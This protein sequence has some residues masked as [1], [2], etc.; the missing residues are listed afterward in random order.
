MKR[1]DLLLNAKPILFNTE[2]V[3]AILAGRKTVTRRV[4]R[5]QPSVS[6]QSTEYECRHESGFFDAGENDWACRKC[7]HGI[8]I[9]GHSVFRSPYQLGDIMY[10]R[11]TWFNVDGEDWY[12][13]KADND[14]N[15]TYAPWKPSIHMPKDAARIFLKVTGV[16]F[17]R[18]Q[19]IN[20]NDLEKEGILF[21]KAYDKTQS[22][23]LHFI[24]LWDSTINEHYFE[25][26]EWYANPYVWVIEFEKV[27]V[28]E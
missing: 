25:K 2:M 12:A 20:V 9:N 6:L 24:R 18:L 7:G 16:R 8:G 1:E 22:M 4:E 11:E 10:V 23:L 5:R 3:K 17:E 15:V 19:D 26:Y 27:N 28:D 14:E 13:F 21:N